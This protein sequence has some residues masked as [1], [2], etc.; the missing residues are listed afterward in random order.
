[1]LLFEINPPHLYRYQSFPSTQN[2]HS[3]CPLSPLR[4]SLFL[5]LE[6]CS[7]MYKYFCIHE[8]PLL[9]ILPKFSLLPFSLLP[10]TIELFKIVHISWLNR[11]SSLLRSL[12]QHWLVMA[13]MIFF[14]L[15][16]L[17]WGANTYLKPNTP[18][19]GLLIFAPKPFP[20]TSQLMIFL[21][22]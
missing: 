15:S 3:N 7:P 2:I 4:I 17:Y 5:S 19:S 14:L 16:T 20:I 18:E 11:C 10:Y 12:N 8:K 1:M 21:S 13:A 6:S 9:T 22:L